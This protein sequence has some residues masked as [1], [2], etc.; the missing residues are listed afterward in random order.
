MQTGIEFRCPKCY[1]AKIV[2]DKQG[3][4]ASVT[5]HISLLEGTVDHTSI[6]LVCQQC[7]ATFLPAEAKM[8][9]HTDY[10]AD[11][12]VQSSQTGFTPNEA[13]IRGIC[14]EQGQLHALKYLRDTYGWSLQEA[15][16]YVDRL[17]QGT[18]N[19]GPAQATGDAH[20]I[21]IARQQGKLNAIKYCKDTYNMGLKEAKDYVDSLML[22]Q[23]LAATAGKGC[24]VA[25]ACYGDYDAP[26]VKVLRRYRD[27]VLQHS[28]AGRMF[29]R[30]YYT[31]SPPLAD[32]ISRSP[33]TK[34]FI[35]QYVLQRL[36]QHIAKRQH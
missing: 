1:A 33:G 28:N 15:K 14:R 8:A 6:R 16:N 21:Q 36:V 9:Q 12:P 27:E 26:E 30:L 7:G 32:R 34:A 3:A 24:F 11:S 20:I 23:G 35:R 19:P 4:P 10:S 17:T 13:Q 5:D 18:A 2:V 29:I 25:T 22:A 31:V